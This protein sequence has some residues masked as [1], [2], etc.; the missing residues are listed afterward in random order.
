[1]LKISVKF[2]SFQMLR[3]FTDHILPPNIE[4]HFKT[5]CRLSALVL[6]HLDAKL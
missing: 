5:L 2:L 4:G 6:D 1:M 3:V